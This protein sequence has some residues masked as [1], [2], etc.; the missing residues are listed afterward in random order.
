MNTISG[1][2]RPVEIQAANYR[3]YCRGILAVSAILIPLGIVLGT[4][5]ASAISLYGMEGL[6]VFLAMYSVKASRTTDKLANPPFQP[7]SIEDDPLDLKPSELPKAKLSSNVAYKDN[8]MKSKVGAN[9]TPF[10]P[11][12]KLEPWYGNSKPK[13]PSSHTTFQ[14]ANE[15]HFADF[16]I[17]KPRFI[18]F[19]V[20]PE[21]ED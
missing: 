4:V 6:A 13:L 15:K 3:N 9:Q 21:G 2:S 12:P 19:P 18:S 14:S 10:P 1:A 5:F 11:F 7:L 17:D 16:D 8:V 20:L